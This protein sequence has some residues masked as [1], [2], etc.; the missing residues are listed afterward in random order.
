MRQMAVAYKGNKCERCG[1]DRC[2]DAL[3]FHH[4]DPS[5]KEFNLS[6]KGQTLGWERVKTE[7]DK[8]I[9]VCANCHRE[10]HHD[11]RSQA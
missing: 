2:A 1:Y 10:I 5:A 6:G 3:E 7:L 9:M 8:C 4:L 11:L